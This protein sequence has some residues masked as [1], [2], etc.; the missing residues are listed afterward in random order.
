VGEDSAMYGI[1]LLHQ[2]LNT[3]RPARRLAAACQQTV[4]FSKGESS[5]TGWQQDKTMKGGTEGNEN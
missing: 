2:C 4:L 1:R 3:A 5:D